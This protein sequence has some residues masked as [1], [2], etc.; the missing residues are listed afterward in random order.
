[1]LTPLFPASP[2][3]SPLGDFCEVKKAKKSRNFSGVLASTAAVAAVLCHCPSSPRFWITLVPEPPAPG[4]GC[5]QPSA[6]YCTI[7]K[8]A[9]TRCGQAVSA[10][11]VRGEIVP[12][13]I[14]ISSHKDV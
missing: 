6:V 13:I 14:A 7:K 8:L 9:C 5:A 2:L 4:P 10:V 11:A 12:I 1:M 3:I